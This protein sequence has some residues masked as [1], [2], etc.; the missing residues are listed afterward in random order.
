V[1]ALLPTPVLLLL[2]VL[3]PLPALNNLLRRTTGWSSPEE[4]ASA[5][6][7]VACVMQGLAPRK[8]G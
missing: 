1:L 8:L 6:S 5:V 7:G 3:V 2:V 4:P